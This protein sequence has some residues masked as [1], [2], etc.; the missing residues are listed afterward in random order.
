MAKKEKAS[1]KKDNTLL[2]GI[3]VLILIVVVIILVRGRAKEAPVS[4]PTRQRNRFRCLT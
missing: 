4:E 2:W 1:V 3:G